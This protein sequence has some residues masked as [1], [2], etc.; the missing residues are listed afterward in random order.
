M[1]SQ[2]PAIFLAAPV[3]LVAVNTRYDNV[4]VLPVRQW[5]ALWQWRVRPGAELARDR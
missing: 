5:L 4:A 2:H 1:S 3:N